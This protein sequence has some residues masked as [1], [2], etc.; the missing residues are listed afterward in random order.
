[1]I[2]AISNSI[3][4]GLSV[5][6]LLFAFYN[7]DFFSEYMRL[8]GLGRFLKINEYYKEQDREKK[9]KIVN[10]SN[11]IEFLKFEYGDRFWCKI[12]TCP[13]CLAFWCVFLV[14]IPYKLSYLF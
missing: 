1:M 14:C 10:F 2:N 13:I 12:I 7:S 5:A 9:R 8:L 3:I 4:L 11:Y 6:S